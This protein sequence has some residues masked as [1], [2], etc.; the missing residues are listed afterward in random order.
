MTYDFEAAKVADR[1]HAE[2]AAAWAEGGDC[3]DADGFD[4]SE[5]R[6]AMAD[7]EAALRRYEAARQ[8]IRR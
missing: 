2:A 3:F 7:V 6:A 1:A 8:A 4:P 5:V